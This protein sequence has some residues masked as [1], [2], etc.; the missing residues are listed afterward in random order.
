[1]GTV[2]RL[3]LRHARAPSETSDISGRETSAGHSPAPGQ[4]DENQISARSMRLTLMSAPPSSAAS[5]LPSFKAREETVD[6]GIPSISAYRRATLR[7]ES[8]P[9]MFH[10]SVNLPGLSTAFLPDEQSADSGHPTGMDMAVV[11]DNIVQL[12]ETKGLSADKVSRDAGVPDAIRNMKRRLDGGI[13]STGITIKTLDALAARL[14]VTADYLKTP[15][16]K[17]KRTKTG[18]VR[19]GLLAKI[20]WLDRERAQAIAELEAVEAAESSERPRLKR[21]RR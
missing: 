16:Q 20:A 5:F 15:A 12:L 13:K 8:I 17:P 1:M 11:Y 21:K 18:G 9:D 2:V 10:I 7:R 14:G 19:E 3:P 4:F 6:R